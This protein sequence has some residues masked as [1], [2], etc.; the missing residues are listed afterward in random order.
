VIAYADAS[1]VLRMVLRADERLPEWSQIHE[2]VS[3][4]LIETECRRSLHRL[5]AQNRLDD[6]AL[7]EALDLV[8]QFLADLD[9]AP[10]N[11]AVLERAGDPFPTALGTLDA[12]HLA[13]ALLWEHDAKRPLDAFLTHDVELGLAARASGL[14][15][16]GC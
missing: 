6:T 13:T 16:L 1:V 5:R 3:S 2:L 14:R 8:R 10:I 15:V 12:I 7:V 11:A 9:T 4:K